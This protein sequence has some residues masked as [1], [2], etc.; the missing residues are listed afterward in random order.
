MKKVI[1]IVCLLFFCSE[2]ISAQNFITDSVME[3]NIV[4]VTSNRIENF[5]IGNKTEQIDS[6]L[7]TAYKHQSLADLLSSQSQLFIKSSGPGCLATS[8]FRGAGAEHTAVLWNGFNIQS[9][10]LGQI[11]LSLLQSDL[12]DEVKVQYGSSGALF[13]SGA[14]G[15]IIH[16]KNKTNFSSG[17]HTSLNFQNG[18]FENN[19]HGVSLSYGGTKFYSSLRFINQYAKNNFP[20]T[21]TYLLGSP[22]VNQVNASYSQQ[23]LMSDNYFVLS[24][25][26]QIN[27]SVWYQNSLR[28]IP[29]S[30]A[31]PFS[32]STQNDETFRVSSEWN[33]YHK[34]SS[35]FIRTAL[36]DERLVYQD[37]GSGLLSNNHSKTFISEVESKFNIFKNQQI[38]IGLNNTFSSATAASY[39]G[40]FEQNRTSFFASYKIYNSTKT[41]QTCASV[42]DEII[43]GISLPI[44]PSL[45]FEW[46]MNNHLKFFGNVNRA[47]RIPTFND[48]FWND[49]FARGNKNLQAENAWAEEI[50]LNAVHKIS[51]VKMDFTATVFNRILENY[52]QWVSTGSYWSPENIKQVWSRGLEGNLKLNFPMGKWNFLYNGRVNYILST[53]EQSDMSND[54]TLHKQLIYVPKLNYMNQLIVTYKTFY[55]SFN[56]T[57]T[58]IRFTD[59]DECNFLM[60]YLLGNIS[61][62]KEFQLKSFSLSIN[63]QV[64]NIWNENY[65]IIQNMPMPGRNYLMGITIKI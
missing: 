3:L 55:A 26:Q 19:K 39:G 4:H 58:G 53:K 64:K 6:V 65:Q 45:G 8:S 33:L 47:Y 41:F 14:V 21:N 28:Q 59:R 61:A 31:V 1:A 46:M 42:R 16:L 30:M 36:F 56:Q 27:I 38:N 9:P 12:I 50:S 37:S 63:A 25:E 20:F 43:A 44:M 51:T 54:A 48:L 11:D 62:G 22:L 15:G 57:Y 60:Y 34:K 17:F 35:Y 10:M 52:I 13:G 29:P 18:S 49:A 24:K 32:K 40:T 7:M 23:A 2:E 5:N